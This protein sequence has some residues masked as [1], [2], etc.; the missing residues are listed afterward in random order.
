ME[1]K[2]IDFSSRHIGLNINDKLS[3][4]EKIG[5]K[6][7]GDFLDDVFTKKIKKHKNVF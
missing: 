6:D 2:N 5:Y 3:M 1:I 7:S 4:L